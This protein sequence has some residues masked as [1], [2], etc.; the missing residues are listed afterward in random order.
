MRNW[1]CGGEGGGIEIKNRT[2]IWHI[3]FISTQSLVTEIILLSASC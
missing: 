3:Y 2:C 1:G